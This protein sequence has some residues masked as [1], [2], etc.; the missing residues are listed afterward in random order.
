M[1]DWPG[2]F[3]TSKSNESSIAV[4][5]DYEGF[6]SHEMPEVRAWALRRLSAFSPERAGRL[7]LP[8]LTDPEADVQHA[9][10]DAVKEH[11]PR[12]G[13]AELRAYLGRPGLLPGLYLTAAAALVQLEGSSVLEELLAAPAHVTSTN[14]EGL[15]RIWSEQD[16]AGCRRKLLARLGTQRG[17]SMGLLAVFIDVAE[18]EDASRL[19][20]LIR[21]VEGAREELWGLLLA[22]A[23]AEDLLPRGGPAK[24]PAL[25]ETTRRI[26]ATLPGFALVEQERRALAALKARSWARAVELLG[27]L[28]EPPPL[29]P[30][31]AELATF[32]RALRPS[33]RGAKRRDEALFALALSLGERRLR[34]LSDALLDP[35]P[36]ARI[37]LRAAAPTQL[38]SRLDE[39]IAAR[40]TEA[41][42]EERE[43]AERLLRAQLENDP[44]LRHATLALAA[45]IGWGGAARLALE[46]LGSGLD[47]DGFEEVEILLR[48]RPELVEELAGD[49]LL[50]R[51]TSA[52]IALLNA[53]EASPRRAETALLLARLPELLSDAALRRE[54]LDCLEE[55]GDPAALEP[56]L[57]EWRPGERRVAAV[58]SF[59]AALA[60]RHGDLPAQIREEAEAARQSWR[61]LRQE[62][63]P[64]EGIEALLANAQDRPLQLD[65]SC[66]RCGR[67]YTYEVE[68]AF[69]S[70]GHEEGWDGVTFSRAIV[71]KGCGAEDDYALTQMAQMTLMSQLLLARSSGMQQGRV[72]AGRMGLA[73]G[74]VIKRFSEG[75]RLLEARAEASPDQPEV[76][77]RLGNYLRKAGQS[78]EAVQSYLRAASLDPKNLQA[79][80]NL[81]TLYWES[82]QHE[83]ALPHLRQALE[84]LPGGKVSPEERLGMARELLGMLKERAAEGKAPPGLLASW[85]VPSPGGRQ[86]INTSAANLR[87]LEELEPLAQLLASGLV[88]AVSLTSEL[89]EEHP[90]R[91]EEFLKEIGQ[92]KPQEPVVAAPK[93][94]R[95]EPCP[96][97]SGQKYKKCHGR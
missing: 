47:S 21:G 9:A 53:I 88:M 87:H 65:L 92:L 51:G 33:I 66:R 55:R 49:F 20:E 26:S 93:V 12:E 68:Q 63:A 80:F 10:L 38:V 67:T 2:F 46:R 32:S 6:L 85:L 59:L 34:L 23:G 14:V 89:P 76:W 37:R 94:G 74:T 22:R 19:I 97:G 73:D 36:A 16:R 18:P 24:L 29:R 17:T 79:S 5:D 54:A 62:L 30:E 86:I 60:G 90:S 43:E 4:W 77:W 31:L 39:E 84:G 35:S 71:C 64:G 45:R 3:M 8:L 27:A 91:L 70:P 28:E 72:I 56:L 42:P 69:L 44:P 13:G 81:A 40:L 95:N 52:S 25:E 82:G 57:E 96:C 78:E 7:A 50:G 75:R 1:P 15:W 11:P 58:I 61:E 41:P 48:G 83:T